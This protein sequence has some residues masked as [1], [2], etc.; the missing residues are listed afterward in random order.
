MKLAGRGPGRVAQWVKTN[1]LVGLS[2]P[3]RGMRAAPS[4]E[5]GKTMRNLT[6]MMCSVLFASIG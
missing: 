5:G 6:V 1:S 4:G 3:E 2:T